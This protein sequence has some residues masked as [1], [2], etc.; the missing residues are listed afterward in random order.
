MATNTSCGAVR[1]RGRLVSR[2]H[3]ATMWTF[4][5]NRYLRCCHTSPHKALITIHS[6][7]L[8]SSHCGHHEGGWVGGFGMRGYVAHRVTRGNGTVQTNSDSDTSFV[9]AQGSWEALSIIIKASENDTD[10]SYSHIES[11]RSVVVVHLSGTTGHAT[12]PW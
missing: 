10:D 5:S 11:R 4:C 9:H 12:S 1:F 6:G 8:P 2:P 7:P 3:S